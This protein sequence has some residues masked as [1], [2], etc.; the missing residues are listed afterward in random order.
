VEPVITPRGSGYQV[1]WDN[2]VEVYV[3]RI[4]ENPERL[5]CEVAILLNSQPLT[6]SSP[7]LTSESGKDSLIRKLK[8]RRPDED[9]GID[10]EVMVEE[11]SALVVDPR[12]IC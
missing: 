4:R 9:W 10:W 6:R 12:T 11:L 3:S 5:K 7:V 1:K 8:R 2:G